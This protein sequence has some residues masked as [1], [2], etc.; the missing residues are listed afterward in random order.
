MTFAVVGF[1]AG[2]VASAL[3]LLVVA[4]A[5]GHT[6]DVTQLAARPTPP[7]WVVVSG[8]VGLWFGFVGAVVL[9][10][11]S[12]GTGDVWRDMRVRFRPSDLL[13]GPAV[14]LAGQL[15][16]LPL[17]Y[18]PLEHVVPHLSDRLSQPAKHLTGGFPGADLAVIAALTVLVVPV[19]EELVFRGLFL[20]GALRAFRGAGPMVGPALA[21]VCTGV[22]FALAHLEALQILGLAAFG[23]VL[24]YLAYRLDRLGPCIVAHATFNLVAILAVATIG[25]P[26]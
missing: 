3:L 20:R 5:L 10:S 9:A 16:L 2:Q 11:R 15:L 26:R 21:M 13:I 6:R 25:A 14:G 8:L 19:V 12:A 22:V 23:V 24:S 18:L 1:V 4:A 17:L 7:A